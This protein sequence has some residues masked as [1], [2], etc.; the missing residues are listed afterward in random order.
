ML[1]FRRKIAD[2]ILKT[3]GSGKLVLIFGPR[4]VG[5]TTLAKKL[6]EERGDPEAYFNCETLSVREHL[7]VGNAEPLKE[8]AGRHKLI[9]LDEA[10]TV[11]NIGAILII[12]YLPTPIPTFRSSPRDPHRST[13]VK[14]PKNLQN[15]NSLAPQFLVWWRSHDEPSLQQTDFINLSKLPEHELNDYAQAI[16]GQVGKTVNLVQLVAGKPLLSGTWGYGI[17]A[18]R[19]MEGKNRGGP[20]S[21]T[22]HMHVTFYGPA[23]RK[24]L[25]GQL[26]DASSRLNHYAPWNALF[27]D[28]LGIPM[29][30]VIERQLLSS[31]SEV[32]VEVLSL[33]DTT[34]NGASKQKYGFRIRFEEAKQFS[35]AIKA[36]ARIAGV[37]ET[38]YAQVLEYHRALFS[39]PSNQEYVSS[40][41]E[42]VAGALRKAGFDQ[43]NVDAVLNFASSISPT[44]SQLTSWKEAAVRDGRV[45]DAQALEASVQRYQRVSARINRPNAADTLTNALMKD[46]LLPRVPTLMLREY[47]LCISATRISSTITTRKMA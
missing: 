3:I 27:L 43:G 12:S 10:Q 23:E 22:G 35:E 36:I 9:V 34:P 14:L 18:E 46:T 32:H 4:Q 15:I 13:S 37:S 30:H 5:K 42:T 6:L 19:A 8:L 11:E 47:G 44:L 26:V 16:V 1:I 31:D 17:P 33:F 28:V 21:P 39:R 25:F 24:I 38:V 20:T 40:V 7:V 45:A 2:Q 41:K 29:A